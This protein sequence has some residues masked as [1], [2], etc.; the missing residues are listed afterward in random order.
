MYKLI[1]LF[2]IPLG[3]LSC[4]VNTAGTNKVKASAP[5]LIFILAD[6]LGYGDLGCYGQ[7]LIHT[8]TLD[9]MAA[10]GMR[11]TQFYAG[12]T[13]CAPSRAALM[14]G[15]HTGHTSIRGNKEIQPEG[16]WPL[17]HTAITIAEMLKESGYV[18]GDFGKWGLGPVGSSGDPNRQGFDHFFGYNCQRQSH[19]FY[20]DHLWKNNTRINYPDN[21]QKQEVYAAQIIQDSALE[22]INQNKEKPFFLY[23]S[24]TLP[25]AALQVPADATFESYKKSFN[26]Q[27][28]PIPASW[29]GTGYQPQAYPH[30]AFATMV[31]RLDTYVGQILAKLKTMGLDKNTLVIFSSDNGPHKEG[32]HQPEFFN[33]NGGFTGIKRDLYEGGIR[34]P[35]IAVWPGKIKEGSVNNHIGA[36]WDFMPTFSD[37]AGAKTPASTDGISLVPILFGQG[38]QQQHNYLYWEFHEGGGKQAIRMGKWKGIRLGAME[39]NESRIALYNLENDPKEE[40]NIAAAYPDIVNRIAEYMKEAHVE[41]E[42][43]PFLSSR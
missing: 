3:L 42:T 25:H 38:N 27:P 36:F 10:Q 29:N 43:F 9:K 37:L 35:M 34:V 13:V 20:P 26:E 39:T 22:F 18:T 32:G 23:L 5:N 33:S 21:P 16:Q 2:L 6:D 17:P 4:H 14:T 11:F 30:A 7:K 28:Q 8:P 24:Y 19:N 12:A 15:M 41:N 1:F 31:T 40:K